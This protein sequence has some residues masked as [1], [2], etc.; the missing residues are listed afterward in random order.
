[1]HSMQIQ[2]YP[3]NDEVLVQSRS[4]VARAHNGQVLIQ[5]YCLPELVPIQIPCSI[6]SH[7]RKDEY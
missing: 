2:T 6:C 7:M 3:G 4:F 5:K 1:M